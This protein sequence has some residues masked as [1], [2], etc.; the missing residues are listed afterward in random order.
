MRIGRKIC[1]RANL[2]QAQEN[3]QPAPRGG[4]RVTTTNQC[5][6]WKRYKLYQGREHCNG[7]VTGAK[8]RNIATVRQRVPNA[9]SH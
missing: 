6:G 9:E 5:Q 3:E 2:C 4:K 7:W 1:N 8:R